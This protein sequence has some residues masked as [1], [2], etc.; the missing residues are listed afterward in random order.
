MCRKGG[1]GVWLGC[2]RAQ[3]GHPPGTRCLLHSTPCMLAARQA[4]LLHQWLAH[5]GGLF[6]IAGGL[7]SRDTLFCLCRLLQID[8]SA[9]GATTQ[10]KEPLQD[11]TD[12]CNLHGS[13]SQAGQQPLPAAVADRADGATGIS[14]ASIGTAYFQSGAPLSL[15][16]LA[17]QGV[18]ERPA[19]AGDQTAP[20]VPLLE[21]KAVG[22]SAA[23][24]QGVLPNML[25]SWG[26]EAVPCT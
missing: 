12:R 22:R 14:I 21:G 25:F 26:Q 4:A 18:V 2:V 6:E 1:G 3:V 15:A 13:P 20:G 11:V 8:F 19:Q 24:A 9:L 23:H 17:G 16:A 10:P 5:P 7:W